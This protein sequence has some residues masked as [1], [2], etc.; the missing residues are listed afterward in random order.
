MSAAGLLLGALVL[1]YP[2][3]ENDRSRD[4]W[5]LA[6]AWKKQ[7]RYDE[8]VR[9]Y[10]KAVALSPDDA[11]LR[12]NLGLCLALGGDP[13]AA[14]REYRLALELDPSLVFP[15]KNLGLLLMRL[16]RLEEARTWLRRA[17]DREPL[18]VETARAL[19]RLDGSPDPS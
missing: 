4:H 19:A 16:G 13:A 12:N 11:V 6:Q 3:V 8:A 7:G 18:D 14:E 2:I 17:H 9:S 1:S 5:M 15:A 10:R